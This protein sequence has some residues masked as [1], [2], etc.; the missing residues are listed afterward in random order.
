MKTD[1]FIAGLIGFFAGIFVIPAFLNI[2][3]RSPALLLTLPWIGS[4]AIIVGVLLGNAIG[5]K[6][7]LF[8]QLARFAAVGFLNTAIDFGILNL[9][10]LLTGVTSGI[11]VGGVNVPGV[12]VA[13]VNA[14]LWNK[15]WVFGAQESQGQGNKGIL[16]DVPK[17]I[18]VSGAGILL[19]SAIVVFATTYAT[20]FLG[21]Q[22]SLWLNIA[23]VMATVVSMVWSFLGF[24]FIVFKKKEAVSGQTPIAPL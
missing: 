21:T 24:K 7:P 23:K 4:A 17:F 14:Y 12:S 9:I 3:Y 16:A 13:L 5:K 11:K 15:L 6:I 20:P 10:S 19:N 18:I 1:Y 8:I 22:G 2:G